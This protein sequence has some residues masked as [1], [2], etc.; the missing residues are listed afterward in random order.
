MNGPRSD[1]T[2]AAEAHRERAQAKA[3]A[4]PDF[5]AF[6]DSPEGERLRRF[7]LANGRG[8]ARSLGELRRHRSSSGPLSVVR[9]PLSVV[10]DM[11]VSKD[12]P[13]ATNEPTVTAKT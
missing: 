5:L 8:L 11:V 9:G 2:K 4:A 3:A 12:E 10:G 13:N 6:D 7:D 1:L